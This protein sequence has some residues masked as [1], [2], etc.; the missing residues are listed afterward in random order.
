[1][2]EKGGHK[3]VYSPGAGADNP[4]GQIFF[5]NSII[6]SRMS[7]A[8]NFSPLNDGSGELKMISIPVTS[9]FTLYKRG[10]KLLVLVSMIYCLHC[11]DFCNTF[12]HI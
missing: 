8:A 6:Q 10:S 5:I 7:F 11:Q 2:F 3:H 12:E 9:S 4:W 1:M